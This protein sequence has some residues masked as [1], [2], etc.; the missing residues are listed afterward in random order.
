LRPVYLLCQERETFGF[1]GRFAFTPTAG[2]L[3]GG[4]GLARVAPAGV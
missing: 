1:S 4:Q 3:S 2:Q